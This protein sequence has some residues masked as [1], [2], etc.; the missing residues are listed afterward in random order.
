MYNIVSLVMLT[1]DFWEFFPMIQTM[2][3]IFTV[4]IWWQQCKEHVVYLIKSS[5]KIWK[6]S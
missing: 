4:F 3:L 1:F 2:Q 6:L 5:Q